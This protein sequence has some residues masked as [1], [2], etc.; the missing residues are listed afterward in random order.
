MRIKQIKSNDNNG[1]TEITT[2]DG[3]P[4]HGYDDLLR[5]AGLEIESYVSLGDYQGDMLYILRDPDSDA[6]A[7]GHNGYG[8]CSG[9]DTFYAA[10]EDG[11]A[12]VSS[13][14]DSL[15]SDL[16]WMSRTELLEWMKKHDWQSEYFATDW[17]DSKPVANSDFDQWFKQ[18]CAFLEE[19]DHV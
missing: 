1:W 7:Y 15:L 2:H 8:S 5:S 12:A 10:L 11:A 18:A 19:K 9:C 3:D 13:L 14:R 6:F 17:V 4:I 16:N